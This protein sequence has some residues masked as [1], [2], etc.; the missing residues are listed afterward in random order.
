MVLLASSREGEE[1]MVLRAWQHAK[2]G[3]VLLGIVPRHPQRFDDVAA[4][5]AQAGMTFQRRANDTA[6]A[7]DTQVWLG[8][9]MG[10]MF[11]YYAACDVALIGGSFL[12]L[13]GQ[14]LLEACAMGKPVIMGPHMFNFTEAARLAQQAGAAVQ[15]DSV[16][17][18]VEAAMGLVQAPARGTLMGNAG[19]ALMTAHQGATQRVLDVLKL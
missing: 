9:S 4:L 5:V 17:A 15:V 18:A 7:P 14:N 19:H 1:A 11:A 16:A 13:G 6:V 12:E 3:N 8:D 2:V 10:E